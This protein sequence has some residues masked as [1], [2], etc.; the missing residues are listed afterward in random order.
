MEIQKERTMETSREIISKISWYQTIEFEEGVIS[1]GCKWCGDPAWQNIKKFL[2]SSLE[3]KRILDL[4]CNAG[5]FCVRS[6]L[7]EA[8]ECVGIDCND[9]RKDS[10]YLE[11]AEFVKAFFEKKHNRKLNIR[12]IEGRMENILQEDNGI[13]DYCFAIASLYYTNKSEDVVKRISEI[14]KNVI[15]RLRDK[16]RI[17]AFTQLF[18]KYGYKLVEVLQEKWWE[19]LNIQTDDFYLYHYAR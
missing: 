1:N 15:V 3:G 19:K 2:P 10:N 13:F 4:G 9:W 14:C 5:I 12:Y 6:A 7:M 8:K 11:Q 18:E 16:P 17:E